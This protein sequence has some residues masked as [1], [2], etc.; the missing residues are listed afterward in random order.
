MKILPGGKIKKKEKP[1]VVITRSTRNKRKAITT[2]NGLDMFGVKLAVRA[3]S[4][5][6]WS[7]L[8]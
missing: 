3:A 5:V 6:D 1:R 4:T 7:Y 2:I 8:G